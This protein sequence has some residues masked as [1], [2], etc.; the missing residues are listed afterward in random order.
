MMTAKAESRS[1]LAND[2][3]GGLSAMLVALPASLAFG[4]AIVAPLGPAHAG[5]GALSGL[6][7][8][9]ALGTIAAVLGGAPRLVSAP[10]APAAA[11]MGALAV[12]L[13]SDPGRDPASILLLLSLTAFLSG[14]LQILYGVLGGGTLIK[15]IPYPV[16]TGYLSGVAIVIFL[17]QL[18]SFLGL[19]KGMEMAQGILEPSS[20]NPVSLSVGG[21][22][23]AASLL[24]PRLTQKV[25]APIVGLLAGAASYF[26]LALRVS[27]LLTLEGNP[28][29]IGPLS[30]GASFWS[31]LGAR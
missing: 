11:V 3:W 15:Y 17:K 4:V 20:W 26:G 25:P 29:L 22:T 31:G 1:A 19:P 7:G 30:G 28:L 24:A 23:V 6:L 13:S 9:F 18:P 16:V 12:V 21:I 27:S 5:A 14:G 8:A 10:C 2:F